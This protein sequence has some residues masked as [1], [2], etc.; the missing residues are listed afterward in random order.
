MLDRFLNVLLLTKLLLCLLSVSLSLSL[1]LSVPLSLCL[2]LCLSVSVSLSL[3]LCLCL[4][5]SL[6]LSVS[7]SLSL[8]LS[9]S[10]SLSLSLCLSL[11]LSLPPSLHCIADDILCFPESSIF[12]FDVFCK[13]RR[14]LIFLYVVHYVHN[15][16][17]CSRLTHMKSQISFTETQRLEK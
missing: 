15:F 4:S 10:L 14:I 5:V 6:S 3:S 1:S 7:V 16:F 11:C 13:F 12:V 2:C 9:F 17:F 8:S